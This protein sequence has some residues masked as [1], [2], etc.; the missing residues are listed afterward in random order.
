MRIWVGIE[1]LQNPKKHKFLYPHHTRPSINTVV[2]DENLINEESSNSR[3]LH[4]LREVVSL[5]AKCRA[6][7]E[8]DL[9]K[10]Y[11]LRSALSMVAW[12]QQATQRIETQLTQRT[13]TVGGVADRSG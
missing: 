8:T 5:A 9:N 11:N 4:Q 10:K 7:S 1:R 2:H 3:D 6:L 13:K 12:V